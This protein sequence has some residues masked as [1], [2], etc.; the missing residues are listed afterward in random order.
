M[1]KLTTTTT[2]NLE[3]AERVCSVCWW[4]LLAFT[5]S[6]TCCC[7]CRG[8]SFI[9]E[10]IYCFQQGDE[11]LSECANRAYG[12][13]LKKHHGWVVR[14]MFSVSAVSLCVLAGLH[15]PGTFQLAAKAAPSRSEF[16]LSL[17]GRSSGT[18]AAQLDQQLSSEITLYVGGID[19]CL[20][21]LDQFY[22]S[23]QLDPDIT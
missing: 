14:G 19:R 5:R 6:D 18:E 9:R 13:T 17:T 3:M 11:D 2:T 12:Q 23:H 10:F 7:T 8:V 4:S 22:K 15:L 20:R 1:H 16:I 21:S